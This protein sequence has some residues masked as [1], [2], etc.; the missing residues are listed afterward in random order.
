MPPIAK[1]RALPEDQKKLPAIQDHVF[2]NFLGVKV[3]SF[4]P[5][6]N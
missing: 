3:G 5:P 4:Y 6:W 1:S 2:K